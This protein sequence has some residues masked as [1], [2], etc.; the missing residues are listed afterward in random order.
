VWAGS[1]HL[2]VAD[3]GNHRVLTWATIPDSINFLPGG[4]LGQAQ[5][6][7]TSLTGA[8]GTQGFHSPFGVASDGTN[9]FVAD[10]AHNRVLQFTSYVAS[11]GIDTQAT[12]VFGQADFSHITQNDPDQNSVVGDQRNNPPTPGITA[13]SMQNPQGV[14]ANAAL[15]VLYVTDTGNSRVLQYTINNSLSPN[16]T[17]GVNGSDPQDVDFCF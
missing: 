10:T 2:V 16:G 13:G 1:D 12:E 6:G 11:L 14:F 4:L 15:N 17:T 5:F 8:S 7:Q 9:L 3:T